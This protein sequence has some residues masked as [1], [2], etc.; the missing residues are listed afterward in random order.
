MTHLDYMHDFDVVS[1]DASVVSISESD[2]G[3]SDIVL[4]KTCF[5]A[6]GGGQD[7]DTG[8]MTAAGTKFLVDEVRIDESG[9]VHHFGLFDGPAFEVGSTV[10]CAVDVERRSLNTR[11][12]SAAHVLDMAVDTLGLPWVPGKGAHYPH[13]SNV[14]Y[15]SDFTT[16]DANAKLS[17]IE[18]LSNRFVA[19]GGVNVIQFM[20][21]EE[22]H[23]VCRHVP[24][25]LPTN[26]P[27]RVV[28]Y[29][30]EFGV[31][32]GG[33]HVKNINDVGPIRIA[34]IKAKKGIV[35]VSYAVEGQNI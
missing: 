18:D 28:I 34:K 35:K 14:E 17:E 31:P 29:L 2:D 10:A 4:D 16:E 5:Y 19:E 11:L 25:N 22:M 1:G 23:T 9:D 6:R 12:H 13:M 30:G 26:K 20:P 7:W 15:A 32:C 8:V 24:D 3:R 21:V 27:A 33:T